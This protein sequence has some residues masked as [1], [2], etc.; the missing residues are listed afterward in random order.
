MQYYKI[1]IGLLTMARWDITLGK[2]A[3]AYVNIEAEHGHFREQMQ[4]ITAVVQ[5]LKNATG[6]KPQNA[7]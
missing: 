6:G 5:G 7:Y 1:M 3:Q 2:K 4:L